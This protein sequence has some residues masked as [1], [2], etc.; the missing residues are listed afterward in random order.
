MGL[1]VIKSGWQSLVMDSGRQD[2]RQW[3][4]PRSGVLDPYRYRWAN[5][6]AG[7]AA[8]VAG[9][10][11]VLEIRS[12]NV[13]LEFDSDHIFAIT[14]SPGWYE[15]GDRVIDPYV[16]HRIKKGQQLHIRKIQQNGTIY[17]AIN[18]KWDLPSY[19]GSFSADILSPFPGLGGRPLRKDDYIPIFSSSFSFDFMKNPTPDQVRFELHRFQPVFRI[20][21]GPELNLGGEKLKKILEKSDFT[22]LRSSNRMGYRLEADFEEEIRLPE[23]ISSIVVPG[24]IQWPPG[25]QPV[26]LLPNCQTTGGYSRVAKVIEADLWKLAYTGPGDIIRFQWVTQTE[27]Q[28]LM[29]YQN[30]Q[31]ETAWAATF[32]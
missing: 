21:M 1:I 3:G 23:I 16:P 29:R 6:L 9:K 28:Y 31:F 2:A 20:G 11:P 26:L 8:A 19:W 14:G 7:H 22:I 25:N 27:A 12:G 18:G 4:I 32:L 30:G 5:G 24:M 15:V 13:I 17:L 10:I